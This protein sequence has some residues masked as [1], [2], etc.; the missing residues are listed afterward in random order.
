MG[1]EGGKVRGRLKTMEQ[2]DKG[3]Q[4]R[5]VG[6][7]NQDGTKAEEREGHEKEWKSGKEGRESV[8]EKVT[9]RQRKNKSKNIKKETHG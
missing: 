3:T 6:Q 8:K 5:E 9:V 4:R 2:A 7:R 1:R